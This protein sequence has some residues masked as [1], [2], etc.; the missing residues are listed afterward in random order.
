[1]QEMTSG[2]NLS[3][4]YSWQIRQ[5]APYGAGVGAFGHQAERTFEPR[6]GGEISDECLFVTE[7]YFQSGALCVEKGGVVGFARGVGGKH[8]FDGGVGARHEARSVHLK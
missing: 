4:R 7:R 3:G 8:G 1:M 2:E 6:M 5:C